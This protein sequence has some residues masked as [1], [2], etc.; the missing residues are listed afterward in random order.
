MCSYSKI[1]QIF[2]PFV[3]FDTGEFNRLQFANDKMYDDAVFADRFHYQLT[4][5]RIGLLVCWYCTWKKTELPKSSH[6]AE[7]SIVFMIWYD[8]IQSYAMFKTQDVRWCRFR[9]SIPT[10]IDNVWSRC[11]DPA[12][13]TPWYT[14]W[15]WNSYIKNRQWQ[16][17]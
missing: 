4:I 6:S 10:S 16:L 8:W 5:F 14:Y 7:F 17:A 15:I 13:S 9:S 11:I 2:V 1:L 12:I 3:W